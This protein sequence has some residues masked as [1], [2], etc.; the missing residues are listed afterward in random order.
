MSLRS[1]KEIH[2]KDKSFCCTECGKLFLKLSTLKK[3]MYSH[4]QERYLI[5]YF[6]EISIFYLFI[7]L[8]H[9]NV[10]NVQRYIN[11]LFGS[12]YEK[13]KIIK[14]FIGL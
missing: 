3:H 4:T 2:E 8:D 5:I 9:T 6:L 1:H 10:R 13:K 7:F 12:K 14:I 11:F